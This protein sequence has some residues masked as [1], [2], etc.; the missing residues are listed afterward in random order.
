MIGTR[1]RFR[2]AFP[3]INHKSPVPPSICPNCGAT[4]PPKARACPECGSDDETGWS[5]DARESNE[6][7]LGIPDEDFDYEKFVERE[8]GG[9]KP[10]P[11][12]LAWIWWIVAFLLLA[13]VLLMLMR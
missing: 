6:L 8:F 3:I 2:P 11:R 5:A 13:G 9:K 12:S 4:V 10:K 1:R 7:D